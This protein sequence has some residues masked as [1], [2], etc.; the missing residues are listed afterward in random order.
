VTRGHA[1]GT[2]AT[3]S[4][5]RTRMMQKQVVRALAGLAGTIVVATVAVAGCSNAGGDD[6]AATRSDV[7][8]DPA[9]GGAESLAR[10]A[11]SAAAAN[12]AGK[13]TVDIATANLPGAPRDVV[14]TARLDVRVRNVER[15]LRAA[16][17]L[18]GGGRGA[19]REVGRPSCRER[20]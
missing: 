1:A 16:T 7:A 3:G 20:V 9:G 19:Q 12:E 14:Y 15:A 13:P 17:A 5:V 8:A 11:T 6:S 10:S 18:D 2:G 4:N